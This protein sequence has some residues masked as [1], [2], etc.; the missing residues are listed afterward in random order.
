MLEN[1]NC[2]E[3]SREGSVVQRGIWEIE[4]GLDDNHTIFK[5]EGGGGETLKRQRLNTNVAMECANL[6]FRHRASSV[7][8]RHFATL[9]RTVFIYL[10]NK[11]ISLSD[12]CLTVHH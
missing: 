1:G 5:C 10:I 3:D 7:Q 2:V 11:Y 4:G 12:I 9:Q 8:D 6:T